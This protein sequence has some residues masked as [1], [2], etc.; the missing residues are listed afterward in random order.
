VGRLVGRLFGSL[1]V[2][3]H[4]TGKGKGVDKV[5]ECKDGKK[6]FQVKP[7]CLIVEEGFHSATLKI[8]I[9]R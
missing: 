3:G 9:K 2:G 4:I 7:P 5:D 6:F 1:E 8:Q